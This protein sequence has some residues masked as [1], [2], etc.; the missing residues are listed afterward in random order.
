MLADVN[1]ADDATIPP[2]NHHV[3]KPAL[4]IACAKD[5]VAVPRLQVE[6]FGPWVRDL[7]VRELDSAHFVQLERFEEVNCLLEEF[8][9]E[10]GG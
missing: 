2:D 1:L 5:Y 3:T 4:F 8:F 7:R 9:D 6:G 10:V